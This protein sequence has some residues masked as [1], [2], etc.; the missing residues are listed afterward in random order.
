MA[1]IEQNLARI[2]DHKNMYLLPVDLAPP[3]A[4][5]F[6]CQVTKSFLASSGHCAKHLVTPSER[7][8][9][10]IQCGHA[11]TSSYLP[12]DFHMPTPYLTVNGAAKYIKFLKQGF[13]AVELTRSSSSD[14]RV[15]TASV[16]ISE[17]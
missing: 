15:L 6:G 3:P 5:F 11:E 8:Q 14:G 4:G 10:S 7:S 9:S 16:R 2:R 12:A 1:Y 13:D 17:P